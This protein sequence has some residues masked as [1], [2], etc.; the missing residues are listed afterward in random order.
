MQ[1][2]SNY[3]WESAGTKDNAVSLI[4]Q[5]VC[6]KQHNCMLA[7]ICESDHSTGSSVV[8]GYFTERLVEWFHHG[9]LNI[10]QKKGGKEVVF[11]ALKGE[12][13]RIEQELADY[14]KKKQENATVTVI[15]IF[16]FDS[17]FWL[18]GEGEWRGYLFNRRFNRIQRRNLPGVKEAGIHIWEGI[19]ERNIGILLC[20]SGFD[21]H[22]TSEEMP[23]VLFQ[24]H[25]DDK[26]IGKR[27]RELWKEEV[28]RGGTE[29]V[30]AVYIR[31]E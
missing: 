2:Y 30:G 27:L 25:L 14:G 31:V 19:L 9:Y 22:L 29:N 17:Y 7:C 23:Q 13:D 8:S 28:K 16:I 26:D 1:Y 20:S 12:L 11:H 6:L 21:S 24:E 5:H 18:L 10:L 4:L 3:I 15:G